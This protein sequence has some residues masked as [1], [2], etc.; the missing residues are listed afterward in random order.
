M[1]YDTSASAGAQTPFVMPSSPDVERMVVWDWSPDGKKLAGVLAKG[2]ARHIGYFSLESGQYTIVVPNEASV[3]SWL[4]DSRYLIYSEGGK[5]FIADSE[6]GSVRQLFEN[7]LVDIR[8]PFIS[9]DGKLLYF[10]AATNESDIW[11]L[12][13][14]GEK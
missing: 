12:D 3:P 11:M 13:L 8:S 2:A 5:V 7:P 6:S 10:T 9:R 1:I 4:P 14:T